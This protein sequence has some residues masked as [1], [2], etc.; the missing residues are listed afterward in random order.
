MEALINFEGASRAILAE[1][2]LSEAGL[3]VK[4]M[5]TPSAVREGC[6]FCLRLPPERVREALDLLGGLGEPRPEIFVRKP[7]DGGEYVQ[8]SE[9]ATEDK[10][11]NGF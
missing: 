3:P 5:P 2:I 1:R 9:S 11:R 4:V 8:F 10:D 7:G 6:G